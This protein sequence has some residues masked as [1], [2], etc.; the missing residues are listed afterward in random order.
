MERTSSREE[1]CIIPSFVPHRLGLVFIGRIDS[2]AHNLDVWR[3]RALKM[4]EEAKRQLFSSAKLWALQ[5]PVLSLNWVCHKVSLEPIHIIHVVQAMAPDGEK[6]EDSSLELE[7]RL[8]KARK[9]RN[10]HH[11]PKRSSIVCDLAITDVQVHMQARKLPN[12]A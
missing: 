8:P 4:T 12:V 11:T 10:H 6:G 5:V 3:S 1:W 7:Y 9:L 2:A